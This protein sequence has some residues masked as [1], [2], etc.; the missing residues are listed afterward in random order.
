M[1]VMLD[2]I[3]VFVQE[4][5]DSNIRDT[6][7]LAVAVLL[8]QVR[9]LS[10][11][12]RKDLRELVEIVMT[13]ESDEEANSALV[14]IREI[15]EGQPTCGVS[16]M[17]LSAGPSAELARW[18]EFVSQRI[19]KARLQ[20]DLTQEDLAERTG[21]PQSH[22]SRLENGRHSPSRIT[23]EKIAEATGRPLSDFDPSA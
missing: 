13:T 18:V 9:L 5:V 6:V 17:A 8:E 15:L 21:L 7:K 23:L 10:D 3:P 12:D 19:R 2:R 1:T 20:A 14:A 11:E 4:I 22:I 16:E